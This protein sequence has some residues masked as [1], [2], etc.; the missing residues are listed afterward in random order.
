MAREFVLSAVIDL[1]DRF[2]SG[3]RRARQS[4]DGLRGSASGVADSLRTIETSGARSLAGMG[5]AAD[6]A[7]T[8]VGRLQSH[9]SSLTSRAHNVTVNVKTTGV[10]ALNS[11]KSSIS[12]L[13]S[14]AVPQAMGLMGIGMGI[15]D[16]VKVYKD[17]EAQMS[18]VQSI[19]G[20]TA[21]SMAKITAKA[22]EMGATTQFSATQAGQAM[23]YMAMAGWNDKQM[24]D[25][26]AGIM[27]LAGASGE[28]LA[29]V[30]D[31]VTD[32]LSAFGLAAEQSGHFADVLAS[33]TSKSNTNV[34]LMGET[35]K[36]VAPIAGAMK[37]SIEDTSIAIGM[38]ANAGI[39][40]SEAGTAL[41]STLTRLVK[42]PADAAKALN[43]LGIKAA[44]ADGT[45]KPLRQTLVELRSRFKGLT[46]E[47]KSQMA[48]SIAGQEAMSGFLAMMN[49]S[50]DNFQKLASAV[51][52]AN[53]KAL[54]MNKLK[55]DNLA[56]DVTALQSAW[57]ALQISLMEGT[58]SNGLRG[59]VQAIKEDVDILH[60]SLEKG[61]DISSVGNLALNIVNQLYEKFKALD[62]VGSILAG[63]A[64]A[65]GLYK[66]GSLAKRAMDALR[67]GSGIGNGSAG[68]GFGGVGQMTVSAGTVIVNGSTAGVGAG[69]GVGTGAGAGTAGAG[70]WAGIK[71]AV[72]SFAKVALPLELAMMGL[73]YYNANKVNAENM[74]GA[75]YQLTG[76]KARTADALKALNDAKA[77]GASG[78]VLAMYQA[79]YQDAVAN[80]SRA[81]AYL[82]QT[83]SYNQNR[84]NGVIGSGIGG[85]AG[86]VL[87]GIVGSVLPGAGTA[88]GAALGGMA[89]SYAGD[90]V[91]QN[92][93]EWSAQASESLSAFKVSFDETMRG[94]GDSFRQLFVDFGN[95]VTNNMQY[96]SDT[97]RNGWETIES[98]ASEVGSY[99]VSIF[100][101]AIAG[102][103]AKF[104]ELVASATSALSSIKST[105]SSAASSAASAV[106]DFA[107][108]SH[109]TG[110]SY[111]RV[112]AYAS[113]TSSMANTGL[114][115]INEHGG[116]LVRLPDGSQIFPTAATNRIINREVKYG[117][118]LGGSS[119]GGI[120]IAGG[121]GNG[122]IS[123]SAPTINITG[124]S[125]TV[126][127]EA[128]IEKIAH[129]ITEKFMMVQG[130]YA[131]C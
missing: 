63:G 83:S 44:N 96:I 52:N 75:E 1:K 48:A 99:L 106:Y 110:T 25:G 98:T 9:L 28:D 24:L 128:D 68:Q 23:Q 76:A 88:I 58:G 59:F 64:L 15:A 79:Q 130:N 6:R 36:Y 21:D 49:E 124:N 80:E 101:G 57:E 67:G 102:I 120:T 86:G 107:F 93:T 71:G 115:Q 73:D 103:S 81:S 108:G 84:T 61:L 62:G 105:I 97:V 41:R 78:D 77:S 70:R 112:P 7:N 22:K 109:A 91:G 121:N 17:F 47:Q 82:D 122:S 13:A 35:F 51:D 129:A 65:A 127:E 118:L 18:T 38:M 31:I 117:N 53:G 95:G 32:A 69:A 90:F 85:I 104:S 54:E 19:S 46:D 92:F 10:Q 72:S 27:N 37:Y 125:F 43:A 29:R 34:A 39:K 12:N 40:G 42:P 113:G 5:A 55:N 56:G 111:F 114:A 20:A 66:I 74:G 131:G 94:A 89:G 8:R 116:E 87:G 119:G 4:M 50:D 26:V 45:I 126:R 100:D 3:A 60:D 14:G 2:S 33:A 30:S 123:T 11:L 16:T